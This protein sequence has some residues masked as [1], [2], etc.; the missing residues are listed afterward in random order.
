MIFAI[1]ED[2][3]RVEQLIYNTTQPDNSVNIMAGPHATGTRSIIII[4]I[5]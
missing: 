5:T 2:E 3:G 1:D 4:I